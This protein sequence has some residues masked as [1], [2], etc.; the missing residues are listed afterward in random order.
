MGPVAIEGVYDPPSPDTPTDPFSGPVLAKNS[1]RET[2][3][4][5]ASVG[6]TALDML[7]DVVESG[8]GT[9]AQVDDPAW[10]KTGT[11]ENYGDAWFCGGVPEIGMTAC[12]WVGYPDAQ[13]PMKTE[14][15]GSP[16]AGGTYPAGIWHD[17]MTTAIEL[18]DTKVANQEEKGKVT[19][20]TE[21][22]AE[23]T[24]EPAPAKAPS[25]KQ[26][27]AELKDAVDPAGGAAV[28][29][30]GAGKLDSSP[31]GGG[32]GGQA[33]APETTDRSGFPR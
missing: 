1:P 7:G 18:H 15:G 2:R 26:E 24:I 10:G 19:T 31:S 12:V 27:E 21:S 25:E 16:V 4:Y 11:T 8:T 14:Y 17:F 20:D 13:Q 28:K 6:S 5:P 33:K 29:V 23:D 9:A 30:P 22:D 32:A 3:V